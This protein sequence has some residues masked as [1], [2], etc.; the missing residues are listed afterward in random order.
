MLYFLRDMLVNFLDL[1]IWCIRQ[2]LLEQNF[3]KNGS[4]NDKL[5]EIAALFPHTNTLT[6]C[7]IA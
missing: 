1:D 4:L 3:V 5:F 2:L 7:I 6:P